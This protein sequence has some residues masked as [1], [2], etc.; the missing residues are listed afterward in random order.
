MFFMAACQPHPQFIPA[1]DNDPIRPGDVLIVHCTGNSSEE[2]FPVK[3][4]VDDAGNVKIPYSR[5]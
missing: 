1:L 5:P 2:P 3:W 4:L